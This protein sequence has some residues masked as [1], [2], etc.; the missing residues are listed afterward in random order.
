MSS[1]CYWPECY[2]FCRSF[3]N[4]MPAFQQSSLISDMGKLA[5]S[6]DPEVQKEFKLSF[7]FCEF[8]AYALVKNCQSPAASLQERFSPPK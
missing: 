3:A 6:S 7:I 5:Y 8:A 2:L 4:Y 1:V